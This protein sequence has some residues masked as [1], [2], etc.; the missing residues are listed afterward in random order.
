[1]GKFFKRN[2]KKGGRKGGYNSGKRYGGSSGGRNFNSQDRGNQTLHRAV[3]GECGNNCEVPF[4]PTGRK[5]VL[6][7]DCFRKG[8]DFGSNKRYEK[9]RF[10]R[11]GGFDKKPSFNSARGGSNNEDVVRELKKLNTKMDALLK[12]VRGDSNGS[13][14]ED[15]QFED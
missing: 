12:A 6:C 5:P 10:D 15:V 3:C 8:D 4:R 9:K 14:D 11:S 7:R 1:M 2:D 13:G